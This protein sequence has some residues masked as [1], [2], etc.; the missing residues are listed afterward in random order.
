MK[1]FSFSL[2]LVLVLCF[3][4]FMA[5][6]LGGSS[7]SSDPVE[8]TYGIAVD[9]YIVGAQF[10]EYTPDG[11]R[12]QFS[13]YSNANGQFEFTSEVSEGNYIIMTERGT[14]LGEPY[15]GPI[16]Q[17]KVEANPNLINGKYIASPLTTVVAKGDNA[18]D[19]ATLFTDN[20]I[21]ITEEDIYD[22][23]M[24]GIDPDGTAL[25]NVSKLQAAIA[26][27]AALKI[28]EN[29]GGNFS[30]YVPDIADVI[31]TSL[32]R[33][34]I[35]VPDG[36]PEVKNSVIIKTSI[37]VTKYI[38]ENTDAIFDETTGDDEITSLKNTI[39]KV[40]KANYFAENQ[41]II[42]SILDN[43][44]D[45]FGLADIGI[46]KESFDKISD[47]KTIFLDVTE[48]SYSFKTYYEETDEP[49]FEFTE[50][51]LNGKN[52][53]YEGESNTEYMIFESQQA[54]GQVGFIDPNDDDNS[55]PGKWTITNLG[56]IKL[57]ADT[58]Y[59]M[60][61]TAVDDNNWT[62]DFWA[63]DNP[64]SK[65]TITMQPIQ[66]P[67][68]TQDEFDGFVFSNK[69]EMLYIT[70]N[71]TNVEV[72][73]ADEDEISKE[74]VIFLN[75]D[76][77]FSV[78]LT[79]DGKTI[80][81][82]IHVLSKNSNDYNV[83]L[84]GKNGN[85]IVDLWV[86]TWQKILDLEL[87][88]DLT[89][90]NLEGKS[91]SFNAG[92]HEGYVEFLADGVFYNSIGDVNGEWELVEY[93]GEKIIKVT[94]E[95]DEIEYV[96]VDSDS[97]FDEGKIYLYVLTDG[98][99]NPPAKIAAT[100]GP[101]KPKFTA[102]DVSGKT[103]QLNEDPA[104][105]KYLFF[106]DSTNLFHITD[107]T[108]SYSGNYS[109]TERGLINIIIDGVD[110]FIEKV[111]TIDNDGWDV[112]YGPLTEANSVDGEV[113]QLQT[114]QTTATDFAGFYYDDIN[115]PTELIYVS[116]TNAGILNL[117]NLW[118]LSYE[119]ISVSEN[120][121][122]FIKDEGDYKDTIFTFIEKKS[123]TENVFKVL[124][125]E[126]DSNNPYTTTKFEILELEKEFDFDFDSFAKAD[127]DNKTMV[128]SDNTYRDFCKD[129][130]AYQ[131][132]ESTLNFMDFTN[133]G[134][135]VYDF[136]G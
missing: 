53:Q 125:I 127:I 67:S 69:S 123:D 95:N 2:I 12:V 114:I 23:P 42:N 73:S 96:F 54:F 97:L 68:L 32:N 86:A 52:F 30:D 112:K 94:T 108:T 84:I 46:T 18:A 45:D 118:P 113:C 29:K 49:T 33:D 28:M 21:E 25:S 131:Y 63:V 60:E 3:S 91:Y 134:W 1:K 57:E 20:D 109:I 102:S 129:E 98:L 51:E 70:Q 77:Y 100:V 72:A 17:R 22:D 37:A 119:S 64:A 19:I 106:E 99:T 9:P 85:E 101:P 47:N 80:D 88:T 92:E 58:V 121:V 87:Y 41:S 79:E 89:V 15:T 4:I 81:A 5:G 105:L 10:A 90:A 27:N 93:A 11:E 65:S 62:V 83:L 31:T 122:S 82:K 55:G 75:D 132:F 8:K 13:T 117:E 38:E 50:A 7:S 110:T 128:F 111:E 136:A 104:N 78:S 39:E 124:H 76:G 120:T 61:K 43:D 44:W 126:K 16:L 35:T 71:G 14:H 6:C 36:M 59:Y 34:I 26:A 56:R 115:S 66:Y 40:A 116:N 103:F 133:S 130:G 74:N 135:N 24:F 107:N 48:D